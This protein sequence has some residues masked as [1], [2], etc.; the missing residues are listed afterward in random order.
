MDE[1]LIHCNEDEN[2]KCQFKID[3]QFEDGEIIEAGINIRNF[4][5]EIIQKLSD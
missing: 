4:A 1:T 5:K 2:D 3:I